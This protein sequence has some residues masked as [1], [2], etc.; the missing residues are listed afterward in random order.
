LQPQRVSPKVYLHG[1]LAPSGVSALVHRHGINKVC[2]IP[3]QLNRWSELVFEWRYSEGK[4]E[5]FADLPPNWFV[6]TLT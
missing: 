3:R 4:A 2:V 1:V 5:R 6:R